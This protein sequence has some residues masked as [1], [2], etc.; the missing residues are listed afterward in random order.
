MLGRNK[1]ANNYEYTD[2]RIKWLIE[3]AAL[4]KKIS[5]QMN[6]VVTSRTPLL[7]MITM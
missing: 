7:T 4:F 5:F 1:N 6:S 3:T 2:R